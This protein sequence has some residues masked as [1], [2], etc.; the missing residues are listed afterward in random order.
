MHSIE[1]EI[2]LLHRPLVRTAIIRKTLRKIETEQV[3][4]HPS[5]DRGFDFCFSMILTLSKDRQTEI[6]FFKYVEG[7]EYIDYILSFL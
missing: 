4:Q 6:H 2:Y 1:F 7:W 5:Q 3:G